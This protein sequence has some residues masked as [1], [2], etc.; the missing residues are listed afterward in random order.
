MAF[1]NLQDK[2]GG[3]FKKLRNKGKISESDVK[4]AMREVR[5]ALLEADV[6]YKVAKD[7][8]NSVAEKCVGENV[9][10]SLTAAQMIMK[11]VRDQ[12]TELMGSEQAR[13]KTSS[14]IPTV[15]MMCGLQGSGKT[16]HSAKLAKYLKAKAV[17]NSKKDGCSGSKNECSLFTKSTTYCS[18][19]IFPLTLIRSRKST[20]C[21]LVYNPT[22]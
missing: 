22:R 20:R 3:I 14:K 21:G 6:N 13:L 10:E 12:L 19:I 15:I 7:F 5:L 11:I 2:L 9:F 4:E 16:T 17:V 18:G 1:N 8:T